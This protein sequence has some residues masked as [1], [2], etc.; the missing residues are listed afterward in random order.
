MIGASTSKPTA[1]TVKA[2]L[3]ERRSI[4]G[5]GEGIEISGTGAWAWKDF[6]INVQKTSSGVVSGDTR[7]DGTAEETKV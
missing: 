6:S 3:G 2:T 7:K 1:A 5:T 4:L